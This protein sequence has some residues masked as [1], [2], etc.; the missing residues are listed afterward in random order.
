MGEGRP[1]SRRPR[2]PFAG[3]VEDEGGVASVEPALHRTGARVLANFP[4]A[5][6]ASNSAF[7]RGG[8]GTQ[9]KARPTSVLRCC[10]VRARESVIAAFVFERLGSA[11]Q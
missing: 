11:R 10:S 2:S 6:R 4:H 5:Q 1:I 7:N 3:K 8:L 9:L